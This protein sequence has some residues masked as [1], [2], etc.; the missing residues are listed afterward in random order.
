MKKILTSLMPML[1]CSTVA[2]AGGMDHNKAPVAKGFS[3]GFVGVGL[4]LNV[5]DIT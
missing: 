5:L 2:L 4:G 3:G 1:L